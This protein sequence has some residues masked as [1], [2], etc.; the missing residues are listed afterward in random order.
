MYRKHLQY[1]II[2]G[3]S[4]LVV[5]AFP[6]KIQ[7]A[8]RSSFY[9][10]LIPLAQF[11]PKHK[12][13][14]LKVPI[15]ANTNA[16]PSKPLYPNSTVAKVIYRNPSQWNSFF[17]IKIDKK[18][19]P[20][21]QLNSPVLY[22]N[23][24]VGIVDYLGGAQARVKLITNAN[25]TISVR[26]LRG[27]NQYYDLL[28]HLNSMLCYQRIRAKSSLYQELVDLKE[29]LRKS[30]EALY[31][32]KG[33]LFGL[34]QPLWRGDGKILVGRGFN[35]S[36]QDH[37]SLARDLI[38]GTPIGGGKEAP[39]IQPDD[40]LITTGLDGI[41][42]EGLAVAKVLAID[43]LE[44]GAYFYSLKASPIIADFDHLNYVEVIAPSSFP[45][46]DI[47]NTD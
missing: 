4:L 36:F 31:F 30:S 6:K 14:P 2:L 21:V 15:L 41:F 22:Q 29:E 9:R 8:L 26:A 44:E 25:L 11:V 13:T 28:N 32:A 19:A 47:D 46:D 27:K 42:P 24:L 33:E 10:P 43:P 38:S 1:Y 17:W 45:I 3:L 12:D 23:A 35:C 5:I 39:I 16:T 18:N 7:N 34:S 40:L 20:F 37:L